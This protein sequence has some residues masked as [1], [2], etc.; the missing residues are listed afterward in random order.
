MKR[1]FLMLCIITATGVFAKDRRIIGTGP[2]NRV[3]A[4]DMIKY[5]VG[6]YMYRSD[7][8][9]AARKR[10]YINQGDMDYAKSLTP[11]VEQMFMVGFAPTLPDV[12]DGGR[13]FVTYVRNEDYSR[14]RYDDGGVE[15]VITASK[16]Y[17]EALAEFRRKYSMPIPRDNPK[18][19]G[20]NNWLYLDTVKYPSN[21]FWASITLEGRVMKVVVANGPG[22]TL[23]Q[24]NPRVLHQVM[25]IH[26]QVPGG[27]QIQIKQPM[28]GKGIEHV[29]HKPHRVLQMSLPGPIQIQLDGDI[30]LLCLS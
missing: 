25:L 20:A 5:E 11:T 29:P 1:L 24:H 15:D 22:E 23:T 17:D 10:Y 8:D 30:R 18:I 13:E 4:Y 14:K 7:E 19:V 16:E 2:N 12:D 3:M 28:P 26:L 9:Y 6:D 27:P 21:T